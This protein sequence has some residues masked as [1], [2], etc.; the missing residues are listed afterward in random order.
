[1]KKR[2]ILSIRVIIVIFW[3]GFFMSIS[4]MEAPLKF[5]APGLRI[6]TGVAIGQIVF[7]ALNKCELFFLLALVG[8]F[9]ISRSATNGWQA[10]VLITA[11][12]FT[13]TVW[14][15]PALNEIAVRFMAG[16]HAGREYLHWIFILLETVKIPVLLGIGWYN[17][18][19]IDF[20]N[21][22]NYEHAN[23]LQHDRVT[24]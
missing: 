14:L 18:K 11:I 6:E 4:F 21:H 23:A 5:T 19:Q 15:L 22:T 16:K 17:L 9:C 2:T 7:H 20:I 24:A 12:L 8:T 13:E 10:I 1:M 3:L